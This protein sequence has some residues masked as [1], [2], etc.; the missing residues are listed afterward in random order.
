MESGDILLLY[1]DGVIEAKDENAVQYGI[2]NVEALLFENQ[3]QEPGIIL[4]LLKNEV[5]KYAEKGDIKQNGGSLSDDIS[6]VI[7]KKN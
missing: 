6:M 2:E 3:D 5:I 7:I 1:T 4:E